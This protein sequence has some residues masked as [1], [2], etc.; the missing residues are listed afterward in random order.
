MR[1]PARSLAGPAGIAV[2]RRVA[3]CSNDTSLRIAVCLPADVTRGA[4][5]AES[6][7][8]GC[9]RWVN[10]ALMMPSTRRSKRS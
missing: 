5:S 10:T 4:R 2:F 6:G 7:R 1:D 3:T 8:H 9:Q